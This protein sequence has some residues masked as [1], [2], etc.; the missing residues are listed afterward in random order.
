MDIMCISISLYIHSGGS[1]TKGMIVFNGTFH[2]LGAINENLTTQ[3]RAGV[4]VVCLS[5]AV[6]ATGHSVEL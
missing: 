2:G 1:L 4:D 3:C 5:G 6:A